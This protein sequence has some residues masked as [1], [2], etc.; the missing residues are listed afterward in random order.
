MKK[1]ELFW[2]HLEGWKWMNE[3]DYFFSTVIHSRFGFH[4]FQC[5]FWPTI[6][7]ARLFF[8]SVIL[9][10]F[11]FCSKI[12]ATNNFSNNW[13]SKQCYRQRLFFFFVGLVVFFVLFITIAFYFPTGNPYWVTYNS[14]GVFFVPFIIIAFYFPTTTVFGSTLYE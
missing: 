14:L 11:Y 1:L 2:K 6:K 7:N 4:L 10:A 9:I 5:I 13:E 12:V 3:N 8:F